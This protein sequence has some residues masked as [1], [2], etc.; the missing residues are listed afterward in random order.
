[1]H[2]AILGIAT[3]DFQQRWTHWQH[4]G[5]LEKPT[6]LSPPFLYRCLFSS[7]TGRVHGETQVPPAFE[8]LQPQLLSPSE[9]KHQFAAA[10]CSSDRDRSAGAIIIFKHSVALG[11][12]LY[13][14]CWGRAAF[15]SQSL[16]HSSLSA[17]ATDADCIATVCLTASTVYEVIVLILDSS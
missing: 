15:T 9:P 13:G 3:Q 2:H 7:S 6:L 5:S 11:W 16:K 10:C 8:V 12:A 4:K 17:S 1:M 14:P